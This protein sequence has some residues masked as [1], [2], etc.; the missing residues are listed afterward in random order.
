MWLL[1]VITPMQLISQ[2]IYYLTKKKKHISIKCHFLR[3]QVAENLV[4]LEYISTKEHISG[5]FTKPLQRE[6]L[7]YL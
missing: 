5:I 3:E 2:K 1:C 7:E 4:K 6:N